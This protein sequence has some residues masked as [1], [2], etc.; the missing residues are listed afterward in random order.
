MANPSVG[1]YDVVAPIPAGVSAKSRPGPHASSRRVIYGLLLALGAAVLV[2]IKYQAGQKTELVVGVAQ[3]VAVGHV[4]TAADLTQTRLPANTTVPSVAASRVHDIIGQVAQAPLYPG[5][6]LDPRSVGT[7]PGL[8]LGAV[9][10]T[11]ALAP[12]QAVGGTLRPGDLVAVYAGVPA[13]GGVPPTAVQ[14]L[15]GVTVRAVGT[16]SA[17]G[18]PVTELVTLEVSASQATTL[19]AAY[20]GYKVDLALVGR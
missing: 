17:T 7:T 2:G 13:A 11:L 12:E 8:P 14:V 19:E 15:A 4:L 16:Q 1:S 10:M 9:A 20:R 5:E 18:G 3:N 6:V